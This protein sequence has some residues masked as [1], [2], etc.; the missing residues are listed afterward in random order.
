M[1]QVFHYGHAVIVDGREVPISNPDRVLVDG[2]TKAAALEYF[3][4]VGGG[5]L[6]ALRERP[7]MLER[8]RDGE[9]FFQRRVPKGAPPWVATVRGPDYD[10]VC[11]ADLAHVAWMVNLGA[12]TFH[13]WPVR[14]GALGEPDRLLIDLDPQAGSDFKA[15]TEVAGHVREV[16]SQ[17]GV[18][19]FPKTSGGRG[20]HLIAPIAPRPWADVQATRE[21][22]AREV[23]ARVPDRAT[24][25]R[26]KRDRGARVLVD[27]GPQTVASAYSIRPGGL[28]SAPL[29]WDELDAVAPQDFD[30]TSMPRRFAAVGDL[31]V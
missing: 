10:L 4:A 23:V 8:R 27:C 19:C 28:V 22:V 3:L 20:L 15:A 12:V 16:L 2:V 13:P 26:L 6:N 1:A 24:T 29:T 14:R 9:A 18:E 5:I 7:V 11:P 17:R 25:A 31:G 21:E 30:V